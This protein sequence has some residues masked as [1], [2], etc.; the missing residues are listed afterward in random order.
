MCSECSYFTQTNSGIAVVTGLQDQLSEAKNQLEQIVGD[1][2]TCQAQLDDTTTKLCAVTVTNEQLKVANQKLSLQLSNSEAELCKVKSD[3]MGCCTKLEA[4]T[5]EI[6]SLHDNYI[7]IKEQLVTVETSGR[8]QLQE[9][10][11][12]LSNQIHQKV[13]Y[14][15]SLEVDKQA[16][17]R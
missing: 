4:S 7:K 10:T 8:L 2:E 16:L 15:E 3:W 9:K 1:Y 11:D 14:C 17:E 6:G 12:K 13:A 5:Q